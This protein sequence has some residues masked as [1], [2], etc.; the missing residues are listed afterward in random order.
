MIDKISDY[1]NILT[2]Y[3]ESYGYETENLSFL[4]SGGEG[5]VFSNNLYI[6]KYFLNGIHTFSN[7][8]LEFI[9]QQFLN[10]Q[11]ISCVRQLSDIICDADEVIFVTPKKEYSPYIGGDEDSVIEILADSKQNNYIFTNFHPK[12]LMYDSNSKLK[13]IDIG[14]SLEP[15]NENGYQNMIRRAFLSVYFYQRTDLTELMSSIHQ[16]G[17][18]EELKEIDIFE[19][20][21][22]YKIKSNFK[23]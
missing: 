22:Y 12:N 13:I 19:K 14:R 6:F 20:K 16:S 8:N 3:L 17:N 7:E 18:L 21:L 1:Q 5:V 11:N 23:N 4:G 15:F 10:N 2:E 9:K